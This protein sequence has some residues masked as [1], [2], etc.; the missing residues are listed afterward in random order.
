MQT[1]QFQPNG[2]YFCQGRLRDS[3]GRLRGSQTFV[4]NSDITREDSQFSYT[5][6]SSGAGCKITYTGQS[7][8]NQNEWTTNVDQNAPCTATGCHQPTA[9][10]CE[11]LQLLPSQVTRLYEPCYVD[12]DESYLLSWVMVQPIQGAPGLQTYD[13]RLLNPPNQGRTF[14]TA[15]AIDASD[16]EA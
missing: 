15:S 16:N 8:I 5:Y 10:Y 7:S 4:F 6:T 9:L 3:Q 13:C 11:G 1:Q 14:G 2:F 12:D